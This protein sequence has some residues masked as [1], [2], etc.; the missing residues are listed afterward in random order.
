MRRRRRRDDALQS[1][2]Q[3]ATAAYQ[4]L[5]CWIGHISIYGGTSTLGLPALLTLHL[6]PSLAP[7]AH[8]PAQPV[9]LQ[10]LGLP[11][12]HRPLRECRPALQ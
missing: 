6:P 7:Q 11:Q 3:L 4:L 8:A 10:A 5:S 9:H 2:F 1:P 12:V